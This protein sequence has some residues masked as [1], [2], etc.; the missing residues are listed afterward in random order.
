MRPAVLER[1]RRVASLVLRPVDALREAIKRPPEERGPIGRVR[2][3]LAGRVDGGQIRPLPPGTKKPIYNLSGDTAFVDLGLPAG[4]W[5]VELERD[6]RDRVSEWYEELDAAQRDLQWDPDAPPPGLPDGTPH[7]ARLVLLRLRPSSRYPFPP[8]LP[9][10]RGTLLWYDGAPLAGAAVRENGALVRDARVDEGGSWALAFPADQPDGN[11]SVRLRLGA[12][13]EDAKPDG[14]AY[15]AAWPAQW[16]V[17]WRRG[18]TVTLRQPALEGRVLGPGDRPLGGAA[19]TLAGEPGA[20]R[21]DADGRW[22]Y[23]FPPAT[24]AGTADVKVRHPAHGQAT[25]NDVP[26]AAATTTRAPVIRLP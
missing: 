12:V 19:V 14:A 23:H 11:A 18:S 13:D 2:F 22:R 24:P 4:T 10:V 26:F 9:L 16:P 20:L 21:T 1:R 5:R 3:R 17:Q 8:A 6:A 15:L 7:P 25:L